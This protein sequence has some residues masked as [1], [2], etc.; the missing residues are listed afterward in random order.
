MQ[1]AQWLSEGKLKYAETVVEEFENT[2]L[3]FIGLFTSENLG[4]QI[5]KVGD[6]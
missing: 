6:A 3:A 2:P 1:L 5:I 4:K